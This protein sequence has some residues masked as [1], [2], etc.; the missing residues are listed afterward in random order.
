MQGSHF[1]TDC[2]NSTNSTSLSLSILTGIWPSEASVTNTHLEHWITYPWSWLSP[3][4]NFLGKERRGYLGGHPNV[5]DIH[6]TSLH[7][8]WKMEKGSESFFAATC[9]QAG[10]KMG[11]WGAKQRVLTQSHTIANGL[12]IRQLGSVCLHDVNNSQPIHHSCLFPSSSH[13]F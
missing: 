10:H 5:S 6:Q 3:L 9:R 12:K 8:K 7:R 1:S 13:S 11:E 2:K 4:M